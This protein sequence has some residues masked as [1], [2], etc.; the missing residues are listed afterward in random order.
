M[1]TG[2]DGE[3]TYCVIDHLGTTTFG[4][5]IMGTT[6]VSR[7]TSGTSLFSI[8]WL[9]N[10]GDGSIDTSRYRGFFNV[11]VSTS[12]P[13]YVVN[14]QRGTY[15]SYYRYYV[16]STIF[17]QGEGLFYSNIFFDNRQYR[18]SSIFCKIYDASTLGTLGGLGMIRENVM[19]DSTNTK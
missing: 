14:L 19:T 4:N 9:E 18:Q 8:F 10:A 12:G 15:S 11:A 3:E 16:K 1:S 6:R 13:A 7:S 17:I 2:E 5:E